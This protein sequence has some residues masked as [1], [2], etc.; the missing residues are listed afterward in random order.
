MLKRN[1]IYSMDLDPYDVLGIP[2]SSS[3]KEI[4]AAYKKMLVAT[5][6]DKMGNAKYFMLVHDAF[7]S[8][9][10]Q[11]CKETRAPKHKMTYTATEQVGKPT[12]LENFSNNKFNKFFNENRIDLKNPFDDGYQSLMAKRTSHREEEDTARSEKV[13]I[14]T[15]HM[16]VYKEP[17]CLPSGHFTQSCYLL[18]ETSISDFSGG[19]G[20]DIM[21]AYVHT[22]GE[23]IDTVKRYTI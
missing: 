5:H 9:Q 13:H 6:P 15:Q 12:K 17:E 4:K 14:P 10:K 3:W 16:V 11:Q 20:T 7:K 23:L 2:H 1:E 8:L 22:N 18:G 21:K 19:G